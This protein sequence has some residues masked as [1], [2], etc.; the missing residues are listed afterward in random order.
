MRFTYEALMKL[1]KETVDKRFARDLNVTAV[2]LIGSMRP[3]RSAIE[4]AADVDLLVVHNGDMPR[5]R[6]IVKLSNDY[7]LDILYEPVSLYSQPRELRADAWR[8][9]SMWDPRLLFQRGRFFEYTQSVVRAQF[10]EPANV[11]KRA[12]TFAEPAREAWSEMQMNP[13]SARP[14]KLLTAAFKAANAVASLSGPPIPERRLLAEIPERATLVNLPELIQNIFACV[15]SSNVNPEH[16]G[17][18][19][20]AWQNAFQSAARSP[21][22]LR[23][24]SARLAYYKSAIETQLASDLPRA[25]IWPMLHTWALASENGTFD[26]EQIK[27]WNQVCAETGLDAAGRDERL[28]ALDTFLDQMDEVFEQLALDNGL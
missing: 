11:I 22:D 9:W 19:L 1:T 6:E 24:H 5:D 23:L 17:Q 26:E 15:A 10:E 8:G 27:T 28:L 3:E 14:F 20:P 12:R 16:I 21:S 18:W 13:E 7:H 4:S 2:F 25:A